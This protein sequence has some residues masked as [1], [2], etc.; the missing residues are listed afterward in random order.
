MIVRM[1]K[2]KEIWN[3]YSGFETRD[4]YPTEYGI[5]ETKNRVS[6][7]LK[8]LTTITSSQGK[9]RIPNIFQTCWIQSSKALAWFIY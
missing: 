4:G 3:F 1:Y 7:F 8:L 2:N 5:V 9:E 6:K